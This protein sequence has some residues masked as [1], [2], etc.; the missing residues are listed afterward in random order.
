[1]DRAAERLTRRPFD[2]ARCLGHEAS[3]AVAFPPSTCRHTFRPTGD[4]M[5]RDTL[6]TVAVAGVLV[7]PSATAL[8]QQQPPIVLHEVTRGPELRATAP[9]SGF[10]AGA[11]RRPGEVFQDC[12]ECPE[13]VV[14]PG[15]RRAL[16]RYEV[17]AGEYRAFAVAT[18]GGAGGGCLTFG[19]GDSWQ[20]PGFP[21]TDRH[22]VTC[23]SWDDA[24][25]YVSWLTRTTGEAYRLPTEA[26]WDR[27]AAGSQAGCYENRTGK[28]GTCP[29]NSYGSNGAGLSD[30]VGN[31][32]EWTAGHWTGD[33]GRRVLRGGSWYS[34]AV[35]RRPGARAGFRAGFRGAYVG[36]RV[37]R[38][39]D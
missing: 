30:M 32:W 22:P 36:F 18:G 28:K 29:V 27:V 5:L 16:G 39:L 14:L 8:S 11:R 34:F 31:V 38:A 4:A 35:N 17:T 37:S 1:M 9:V 20:D 23:V 2:A 26:E 13:M 10:S 15:G 21:Q 25:E 19:D 3:A 7:L 12:A 33:S 6:T 24:Q